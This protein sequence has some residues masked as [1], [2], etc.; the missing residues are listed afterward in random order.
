MFRGPKGRPWGQERYLGDPM[1]PTN[2][3]D[4]SSD[5]SEAYMPVNKWS[6]F[7]VRA[8]PSEVVQEVLADLLSVMMWPTLYS[9]NHSHP[10]PNHQ[11]HH[12]YYDYYQHYQRSTNATPHS[13]I[14]HNRLQLTASSP[15]PPPSL[16]TSLSPSLSVNDPYL[17]TTLL[18]SPSSSS[19]TFVRS[20]L[21]CKS[22]WL[23]CWW[24][25]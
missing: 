14:I 17:S 20:S 10:P 4:E 16:S 2:W 12:Q 15:P 8:G 19:V 9:I 22:W 13:L 21:H 1:G 25:D 18:M 24:C 3:F 7:L 6:R 11:Y 5:D 23:W